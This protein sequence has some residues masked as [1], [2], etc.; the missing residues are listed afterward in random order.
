LPNGQP[1][2]AASS[3]NLLQ[4]QKYVLSVIKDQTTY[5]QRVHHEHHSVEHV[6]HR[7]SLVLFTLTAMAIG[8]HFWLHAEWLLIFTAFFP[9]LAAGIHG[10]STS[11]EIARLSEQSEATADQLEDLYVATESVLEG[12]ATLWQ[13][14][15]HLRH[16]TS[17]ASEVMSDENSQWQKLVTHQKPKLPA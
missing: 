16:L 12:E 8:A 13:K 10:L 9:A 5:H 4:I 1:Y 3:Q 14:W 17:L 11:L 7:L 15:T 6:L 2:I